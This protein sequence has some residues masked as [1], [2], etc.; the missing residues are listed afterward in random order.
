MRQKAE[1]F[2][3]SQLLGF[4]ASLNRVLYA[5]PKLCLVTSIDKLGLP[6]SKLSERSERKFA[7]M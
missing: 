4:R 6:K 7:V 3:E 2:L 5:S 1:G